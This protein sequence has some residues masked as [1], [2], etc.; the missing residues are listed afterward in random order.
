MTQSE[1]IAKWCNGSKVKEADLNRRG[2]FA[3]VC[4]CDYDACEGWAMINRHSL[5]PHVDLY[6]KQEDS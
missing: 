4:D 2:D 5:I 6:I 3:V 1:F